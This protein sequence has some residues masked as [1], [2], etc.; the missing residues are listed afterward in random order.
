MAHTDDQPS[1]PYQSPTGEQENELQP[2]KQESETPLGWGFRTFCSLVGIFFLTLFMAP[3]GGGPADP[4]TAL[5]NAVVIIIVASVAFGMG[6]KRGVKSSPSQRVT[7]YYILG[8][9]V[10]LALV[11]GFWNISL[12]SSGR[13]HYQ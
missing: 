8:V 13:Y 2:E 7:L 1:N 6:V 9:C 11:V 10:F 12:M 5:Q 3:F 4:F